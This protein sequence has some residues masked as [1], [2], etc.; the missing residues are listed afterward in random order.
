MAIEFQ[1]FFGLSNMQQ[2]NVARV[3]SNLARSVCGKYA[4]WLYIQ[5]VNKQIERERG[6]D[7]ERARE[8]ESSLEG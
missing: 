7:R 3:Q 1:L 8:R 4:I 6:R 5:T 2:V